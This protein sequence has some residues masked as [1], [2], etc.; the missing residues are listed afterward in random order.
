MPVFEYT[1]IEKGTGKKTRGVVDADTLAAARG[2]LRELSLYPTEIVESARLQTDPTERS[3]RRLR[4]SRGGVSSRDL[5]LMTRQLATLLQAGMPL[6]EALGALLEQT[7]KAR[8]KSIIFEIRDKVNSGAGL[9]DAIEEHPRVFSTLYANMVR[10]GEMSGTLESVLFRLA[11]ILERQA[12][13]KGQIASSLAYPAFMALFA[14]AIIVFLMLVIVP[15][16]Q[17]IFEKQEQELPVLT[18][19]LIN[20][21]EFLAR[22]APVIVLTGFGVVMLWRLWIARD[23]GRKRW[24]RWKL[25][26]PLYG[27][28]HLKLVCARLART[29]GTMLQ[30]GLTMMRALE[31]VSTVID[32]RHIQLR[33]EDV[34]SGVRRGR[35]L[36]VPL[37]ETGIFP[38]MMIH[39]IDLGQR[40]GEIEDMLVRVADTYD[41]DVRLTVDALVGLLEPVIIIL[42][43]IFVGFLV[44]AILLPILNMST[45]IGG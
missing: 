19:I 26:F 21:S 18:E 34:K 1:A 25:R 31:V 2:K 20:S 8:L 11:D 22:Y 24:D 37:K 35:D 41:D 40:S 3:V 7:S 14:V 29:L 43:G 23:E 10:A 38:P 13:L 4:R 44:L 32:N 28:L 30:S 36:A 45:N 17:V 15:R 5:A 39:M 27:N 33:M 6:I 42:M 16:I 12:K 9:G